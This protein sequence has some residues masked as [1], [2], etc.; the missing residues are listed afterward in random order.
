MFLNS[1]ETRTQMSSDN[2][3]KIPFGPSDRDDEEVGH[4]SGFVTPSDPF[5]PSTDELHD[6]PDIDRSPAN[7]PESVRQ[8]QET[9]DVYEGVHTISTE[10]I[11]ATIVALAGDLAE[12]G[13]PL[14]EHQQHKLLAAVMLAQA[15]IR[16]LSKRYLGQHIMLKALTAPAREHGQLHLKTLRDHMR[17]QAAGTEQ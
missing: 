9:F 4:L 17:E 1:Y 7:L 10:V 11:A 14:D 8:I 3:S 2:G 5:S 15:E 13:H 12:D 16:D 6:G